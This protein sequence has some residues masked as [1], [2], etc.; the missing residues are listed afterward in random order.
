MVRSIVMN[1]K[2]ENVLED[3]NIR[4]IFLDSQ[5]EKP[6]SVKEAKKYYGKR[7]WS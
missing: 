1:N 3:Y 5:D 4:P 6:L 2:I 7:I